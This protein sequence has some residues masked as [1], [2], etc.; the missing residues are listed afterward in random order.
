MTDLLFYLDWITLMFPVTSHLALL[1]VKIIL[2]S[3][4]VSLSVTSALTLRRQNRRTKNGITKTAKEE[5][6]SF[7]RAALAAP[8]FIDE[9]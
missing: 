5:T 3:S 4:S 9:D 2:L 6:A 8:R 7:L 1:S